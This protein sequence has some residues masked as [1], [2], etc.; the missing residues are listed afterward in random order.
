M[1]LVKKNPNNFKL[2][3]STKCNKGNKVRS[4]HSL[5]TIRALCKDG[6]TAQRLLTSSSWCLVLRTAVF[7][8][9][10]DHVKQQNCC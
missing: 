10:S 8:H 6:R 9:G 5:K 1:K 2:W 3:K 4:V 7:K